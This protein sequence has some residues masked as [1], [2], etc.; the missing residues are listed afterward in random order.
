M[1]LRDRF[2]GLFAKPYPQIHTTEGTERMAAG[3][4]CSRP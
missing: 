2:R 1:S 4:I 3:A